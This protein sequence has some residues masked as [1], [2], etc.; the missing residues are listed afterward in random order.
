MTSNLTEFRG[1]SECL[2]YIS[3][4]GNKC[5]CRLPFFY[6]NFVLLI[7]ASS[8]AAECLVNNPIPGISCW[9]H[10]RQLCVGRSTCRC[11][12]RG[13]DARSVVC[14]EKYVGTAPKRCPVVKGVSARLRV[15]RASQLAGICTG[16][17]TGTQLPIKI[18][19]LIR[20]VH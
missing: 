12:Y 15:G 3:L 4:V 10:S 13:D 11:G 6:N 7:C 5:F 9:L 18:T 19:L 8:S 2:L 17:G 14:S 20:F 16:S 1:L